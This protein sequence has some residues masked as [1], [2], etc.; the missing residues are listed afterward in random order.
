MN[1]LNISIRKLTPEDVDQLREI[2]INTF[3]KAFAPANT[4]DNIQAYMQKAFTSES[5][6]EELNNPS[7]LFYFAL[8]GDEAIG[9]LK[10]N[11]GAAQTDLR[12]ETG[13]EIER[14]YVEEQ[15]QGH[16]IG[17]KLL[18]LAI[19]IAKQKKSGFIWLGVWEKNTGAI[20]FYERNGFIKFSSHAFMLGTDRQTD[21][22]MKLLIE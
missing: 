4:Q 21:I 22:I 9:Y 11:S 5:L 2:S 14:I 19:D 13:L 6:L 1:S 7:S 17:K 18:D 15:Y 16:N 8:S 12:N 10:L 20:R 3:Y